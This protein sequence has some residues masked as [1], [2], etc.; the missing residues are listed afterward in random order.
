MGNEG[1]KELADIVSI[2]S[3]GELKKIKVTDNSLTIC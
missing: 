3:V 2:L 1:G